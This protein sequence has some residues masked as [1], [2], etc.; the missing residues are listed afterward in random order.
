MHVCIL[1]P[2]DVIALL[3]YE[4]INYVHSFC[5]NKS[6]QIQYDITATFY[7]FDNNAELDSFN[8]LSSLHCIKN[9]SLAQQ[10]Q[11][12]ETTE[13]GDDDGD[14]GGEDT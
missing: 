1:L 9:S 3:I 8:L 13:G 4:L 2:Q 11:A 6:L 5:S 14:D 12:A 10:A 7:L